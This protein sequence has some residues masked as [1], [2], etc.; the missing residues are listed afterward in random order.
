MP[1]HIN[2]HL[3]RRK[4][5]GGLT[6]TSLSASAHLSASEKGFET[7]A[8]LSDTHIDK[9][10]EFVSRQGTHVANNLRSVVAEVLAEKDKLTGV[11]V[12]GDCA[13]DEGLKGDYVVL[14]EIL[15]PLFKAGLPVH[16]TMGNHD[17]RGPFFEVFS[18]MA[19]QHRPVESKHVALVESTFAN[20]VFLDSL[21]FVNKV[22]GEFGEEQ[23]NWLRSV[24]SDHSNKPTVLV[25]HHYLQEFREDVIPSDKPIRI[26]GLVDSEAFVEVIESHSNA[27]AYIFGHSHNW[28]TESDDTGFHQI[29]LPPTAY[30]FN[31]D[32]PSGWVK[33]QFSSQGVQLELSALDKKHPE[34]GQVKSLKWR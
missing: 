8:L 14:A 5:I 18:D 13:L 21:R 9:D 23:L 19:K 10:S 34:H 33:A 26:L 32:R 15:A 1:I 30:V 17:D 22:E 3:T 6:A 27:K 7:W 2:S 12:D 11:L 24:L 16:L 31:P 28:N 25:G 4:F 29:N 20:F